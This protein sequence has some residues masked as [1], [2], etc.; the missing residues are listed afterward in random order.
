MG[1]KVMLVQSQYYYCCTITITCSL[2]AEC[3]QCVVK[4]SVNLSPTGTEHITASKDVYGKISQLTIDS[5][6]FSV[7]TGYNV[8]FFH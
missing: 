1:Q 8:D 7:C 3:G 5:F 6:S 2:K 4:I